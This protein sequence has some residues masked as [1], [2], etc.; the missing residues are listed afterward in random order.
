MTTP[1]P[2]PAASP[3]ALPPDAPAALLRQALRRIGCIALVLAMTALAH[4]LASPAVVAPHASATPPLAPAAPARD[5]AR[6]TDA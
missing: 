6:H 1:S 3:V 2:G 4:E 5:P